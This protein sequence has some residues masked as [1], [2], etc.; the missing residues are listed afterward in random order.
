LAGTIRLRLE[1][2]K[3]EVSVMCDVVKV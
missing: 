3:L 1:S 2:P